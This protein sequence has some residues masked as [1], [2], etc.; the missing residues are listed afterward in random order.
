MTLKDK[1]WDQWIPAVIIGLLGG[2][3]LFIVNVVLNKF[4]FHLRIDMIKTLITAIVFAVVFTIVSYQWDK[5][6]A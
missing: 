6:N 4:V 3:T 2:I 1:D 5:K